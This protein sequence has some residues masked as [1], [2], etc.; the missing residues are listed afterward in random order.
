AAGFIILKLSEWSLHGPARIMERTLAFN[1]SR[2]FLQERFHQTLH[3]TAKWHQDHHSGA[4]INRIRKAYEAL[5]DF[6]DRGFMYLYTITKFVFSVSAILYF[7]PFFGSIAVG[8]GIL[9]IAVISRFDKPYIKTLN[10]INERE[11]QVTSNLFDSLSNI[12][13][14][15]TLRLEAS[16]EKGLLNK[17]RR[18]FRPFRKNAIINEWKW[19]IADMLI[20]LIYCVV[21][22][23]FVYQHWIPGKLFFIG[24][25][26]TLLGYVNQFTSVFQNVAGQYTD[27]VQ[28][29]TYING[30]SNIRDAYNEQ[31]RADTPIELPEKWKEIEIN[32]LNFSHRSSYDNKFI[33]QSLHNIKL[34]IQRGKK[35]A[36]IGE[37][38]SGKSTLLSLLRGLYETQAGTELYVDGKNYSFD[39][40]NESVTLFPQ[41][42]EI[43]ENTI[44]FNVT[45]GLPFTDEEII[46]VCDNAHFSEVVKNLPQGLLT[47]IKEKGVNLS[48]GQK[49]RLALARGILAAKD[50]QVILLDEPTSSVDPRTELLIHEKIFKA[51]SDKA[52]ISSIHR[53]HLLN[54]FDYIYVLDKGRIADEGTFEYLQQNSRHF[55]ELWKH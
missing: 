9:N 30:A 21:V 40:L 23:G 48:G 52:I 37:S 8:L 3:L 11:H 46:N 1:I 5:R 16:M 26:V 39:S 54:H 41:E 18:V 25:L 28:Y 7:S 45:L 32:N 43:F 51:F 31:H 35:T 44:A 10:E 22:V 38:G 34:R 14:I 27:I 20:A 29:N 49:Q 19:F 4:T 6:F 12:R 2:N 53:L 42:P 15:I 13:T 55:K 33:P 36:L 47:D 24:G 17:V 50:S